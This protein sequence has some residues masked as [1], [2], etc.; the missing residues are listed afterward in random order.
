MEQRDPEHCC[1]VGCLKRAFYKVGRRGF[2]E[3]L[4][5][6]EAYAAARGNKGSMAYEVNN[7]QSYMPPS[8]RKRQ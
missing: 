8:M 1:I 2:C 7:E 5:K 3:A 6:T 4:H